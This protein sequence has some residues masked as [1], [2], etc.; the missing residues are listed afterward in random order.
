MEVPV[1]LEALDTILKERQDEYKYIVLFEDEEIRFLD[2]YIE[3]SYRGGPH[4]F[5]RE[6]EAQTGTENPVIYT[7]SGVIAGSHRFAQLLTQ[8]DLDKLIISVEE[9]RLYYKIRDKL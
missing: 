2:E 9:D 7:F 1:D 5:V 8:K 3:E 6:D 4:Y